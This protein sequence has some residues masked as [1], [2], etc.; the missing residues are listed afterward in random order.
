[1]GPKNSAVECD[2]PHSIPSNQADAV[3]RDQSFGTSA[4]LPFSVMIIVGLYG[5]GLL[6][7]SLGSS[8][9]LTVHESFAAQPAR[10]M[11]GHG[12][13]L[14]PHFGRQPRL[15]KPPG[16]S[17]LIAG[18]M[19]VSGSE[20]EWIARIPSVAAAIA[21]AL[22]L[23]AWGQAWCRQQRSW[24]VGLMLLTSVFVWMQGRLAEADMILCAFVTAAMFCLYQALCVL[25]NHQR[26]AT[27]WI[28]GFY[29]LAGSSVVIKLVIGPVFLLSSA[30]A[31]AILRGF[32]YQDWR[33][34]R[35]LLSPA[36]G[37]V[38]VLTFAAWPTFAALSQ[39][40]LLSAWWS[41]VFGRAVGDLGGNKPLPFYFYTLPWILL[42][43]TPPAILGIWNARKQFDGPQWQL[44]ACWFLPGFL[45]LQMA[46]FKHKHYLLP[47]LP[48]FLLAAGY[49]VP[50]VENAIVNVLR[51]RR[52]HVLLAGAVL[53]VSAVIAAVIVPQ[54]LRV[55]VVMAGVPCF[56]FL[57]LASRVRF[58]TPNGLA[59]CLFVLLWIEGALFFSVVVSR[60]DSYRSYAE[61]AQRI[62][63]RDDAKA[64]DLFLVGLG[65]NQIAYYLP[66]RAIRVDSLNTFVTDVLPGRSDPC[67]AVIPADSL[68]RLKDVAANKLDSSA[69]GDMRREPLALVAVQEPRPV[70]ITVPKVGISD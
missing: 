2:P 16:L 35:K 21:T 68:Y 4:V 62:N 51:N 56:A 29:A 1:M 36:G 61:L 26:P 13:W 66:L 14:V 63:Q 27:K 30:A 17:W 22:I 34:A 18:C 25:E 39:P 58:L 48:P 32:G 7:I 46:A 69:A 64:H 52:H 31:F 3:L 67:M 53:L 5:T 9:T 65:E 28:L 40:E 60:H 49:S 38:F 57:L 24:I 11:L 50:F 20:A 33:A 37:I 15:N 23:A 10:E 47:I 54:E 45:I 6:G 43:W 41:Q 42:P 55:F 70:K 19:A 12:T 59:V 8:R 44:L